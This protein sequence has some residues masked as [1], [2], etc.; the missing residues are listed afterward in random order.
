MNESIHPTLVLYNK[1]SDL[2]M[3]KILFTRGVC[4]KAPYF[5]TIRPLITGLRPG[6]GEVKIR[7]RRSVQ[8]HLGTVHAIAMCNMAELASGTMTEISVPATHRWIPK[9]MEVEYLKKA[10]TDLIAVAR[11]ELPGQWPDSGDF[12]TRVEVQNI[13]GEVVA[14]MVITMW[15]SVKKKQTA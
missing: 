3:G 10:E 14:R 12:S 13:H 9:G 1:L 7:K 4:F 5:A 2:P 6:Y 15:V 11:A 8:N